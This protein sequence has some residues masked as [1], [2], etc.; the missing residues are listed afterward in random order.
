[1]ILKRILAVITV[2]L[3]VVAIVLMKRKSGQKLQNKQTQEI[4]NK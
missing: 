1:M 4:R 2:V 3:V